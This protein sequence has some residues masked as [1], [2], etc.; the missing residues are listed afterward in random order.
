[1]FYDIYMLEIWLAL[2]ILLGAV[3]GWLTYSAGAHTVW[4][5]GWFRWGLLI[6]VIGVL[7]AWAALLPGRAGFWL[8]S[9]LFMFAAYVIGCV[10]GGGLRALFAPI[11]PA[12]TLPAAAAAPRAAVS[13]IAPQPAPPATPP[14]AAAPAAE[15]ASPSP[16]PAPV[17]APA[18]PVPVAATVEDPPLMGPVEGEHLHEGER[19]TG[20]VSARGGVPDDLKRIRGIGP[21]N[22]GRLH[23]LGVWHFAQIAAWS[24]ENVK[25]VGSYLAFPGRIDR[26]AWIEQATHL[27]KG[28]ETDFSRRVERGEVATSHDGGAH[29]QNNIADLTNI[30]PHS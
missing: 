12:Q 11:R 6:W 14:V 7:V 9:A 8:E 13:P 3:V 21:Q 20:L 29:G 25:W 28:E 19:P 17:A 27:A 10:L 24:P 4:L 22:E 2:A 5:A 1:M 23:A 26:E 15:A 16:A 18:A 30:K